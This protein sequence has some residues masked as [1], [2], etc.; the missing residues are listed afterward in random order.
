MSIIGDDFR[1][2]SNFGP[3]SADVGFLSLHDRYSLDSA[4]NG[5]KRKTTRMT[6]FGL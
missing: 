2:A 1:F 6:R 5:G 4:R 3:A